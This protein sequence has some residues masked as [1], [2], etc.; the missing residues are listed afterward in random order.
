MTRNH[1]IETWNTLPIQTALDNHLVP[2]IY[3]DVVFDEQIGGTILSTEELF[4]DLSK[5]LVPDVILL[6]G[7]EPGVWQNYPAKDIIISRIT[8]ATFQN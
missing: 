6:A 3:G 5:H 2:L 7:I 8:P 4:I 1:V